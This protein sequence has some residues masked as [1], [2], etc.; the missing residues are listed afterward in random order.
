MITVKIGIRRYRLPKRFTIEQWK[1]VAALDIEDHRSWP[2]IMAIGFKQPYHKFWN[3]EEEGLILGAS[4]VTTQMSN[5][6]E[7]KL[8]DFTKLRLGEFID[9]DIYLI[10]GIDKNIDAIVDLLCIKKPKYVDE[11]LWA[12]DQY[13]QFRMSTYRQ[14]SGLFGLNKHGE[15]EDEEE[16][17]DPQKVAKG[18]YR[19]LVNLAQNDITKLDEV[20]ELPL[21]FALNFMALQKEQIL[22]ENFNKL[23][24]KRQ[25]DLQRRNR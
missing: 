24:Q 16:D 4:L 5:R 17:W 25:H 11:A 15:P 22:E 10:S 2:K 1:K 9:L 6:R 13:A 8:I 23:K 19:V 18:W 14:Y 7:C 20:T 3:I 21:K 12:I